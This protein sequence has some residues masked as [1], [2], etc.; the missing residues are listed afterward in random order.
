MI[1]LYGRFTSANEP[2]VI[3]T[4][5][6]WLI[7]KMAAMG[8]GYYTGFPHKRQPEDSQLRDFVLEAHSVRS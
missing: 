5:R 7:E 2:L 1:T 3:P 4:H 6:R 8:V